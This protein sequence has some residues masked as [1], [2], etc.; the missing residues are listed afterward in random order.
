[1][2]PPIHIWNRCHACGAQP[3]AGQRFSCES[4]PAGPENDLCERC[5]RG[6]R[7]G[8]HATAE[9]CFRAH[10]G[11][12]PER[13]EPWLDATRTAGAASRCLVPDAGPRRLVAEAACTKQRHDPTPGSQQRTERRAQRAPFVPDRFVVRPEFRVGRESF[14]G[15]Y[16]FVINDEHGAGPLVL[17]A[18]HVMDELL[19][20]KGL[21]VDELPRVVTEV[22]LYD[23]FAKNWVF[24]DL[25]T[26]HAMLPL[27]HARLGEEEPYTHGD[28][29]AFR[30]SSSAQFAPLPLA[31]EAPHVGE[32]LW[33]AYRRR[34]S[35]ERTV[36]ATVVESTERAFVFRFER[37]TDVAPL[38]SGA[39]LL[40]SE[41]CVAGINIGA[42]AFGGQRFGHA[43]PVASIRRHL[44][45]SHRE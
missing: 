26:A 27:P 9:H 13:Y 40:D 8:A 5:F 36:A 14:F 15:A 10:Q 25:G 6:G 32:P 41:G 16:A 38:S 34:D 12:A 28:I 22:G 17:T 35:G 23:V 11:I 24:A 37:P 43:N 1:M 4:C 30:A 2:Q 19:K 29:A 20:T 7:R 3:I 21:G 39:P 42:G 31:R 18:L 33:L 45:D 44:A